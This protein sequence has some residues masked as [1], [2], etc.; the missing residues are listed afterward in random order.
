MDKVGWEVRLLALED[1]PDDVLE[2]FNRFQVT[3]RMRVTWQDGYR[4]KEEHFTDDWD[5][6]WKVRVVRNLRTCLEQGGAV[7]GAFR[8]GTLLAFAN[9]ESEFFGSAKSYV[10]LSYIHVSREARHQGLGKELFCLCCQE[11][12]KMGAKKLYISAHPAEETQRFYDASGCVPAKEIDPVRYAKE[13]FDIQ[14]EF[15]LEER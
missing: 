5:D 15:D 3:E 13:P 14:L 2:S 7:A 9:V 1:L 8:E 11:A 6:K 10:E 4:L 12:K